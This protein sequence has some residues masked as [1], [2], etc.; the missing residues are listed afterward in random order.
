MIHV[1]NRK[2]Y[3]GPGVYIGRPTIFGN[4]FPLPQYTR[5]A[6]IASYRAYASARYQ[7]DADFRAALDGLV[8]QYRQQGTLTLIC[9]CAPLACHGDALA[10]AIARL[11]SR[12]EEPS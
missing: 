12:H 1:V 10:A 2:T 3:R 4:P 9:H 5:D 6:S 11:A 8:V 7:E